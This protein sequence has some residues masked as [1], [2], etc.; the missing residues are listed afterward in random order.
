MK[1]VFCDS[2]YNLHSDYIFSYLLPSLVNK[3]SWLNCHLIIYMSHMP[4]QQWKHIRQSFSCRRYQVVAPCS[5][6]SATLLSDVITGEARHCNSSSECIVNIA[7]WIG[8]ENYCFNIFIKIMTA[9]WAVELLLNINR[10]WPVFNVFS[11]MMTVRWRYVC[12][13]QVHSAVELLS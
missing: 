4:G 10:L 8:R 5:F 9:Y 3:N 6:M 7:M 12:Q 13:S 2:I 11:A 1:F